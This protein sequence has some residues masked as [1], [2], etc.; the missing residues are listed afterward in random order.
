MQDL[1][2]QI[3]ERWPALDSAKRDDIARALLKKLRG[4]SADRIDA[5]SDDELKESLAAL[6]GAACP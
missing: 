3:L 4:R 2:V 1:A 5:M 6:A